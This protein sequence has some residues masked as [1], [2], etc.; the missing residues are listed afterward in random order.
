[1]LKLT[2]SK[3]KI[4]YISR[5]VDDPE[6]R[7]PDIAL[8]GKILKWKPEVELEKG[9]KKTIDYFKDSIDQIK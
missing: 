5:P 2:N 6:K 4:K 3:S 7:K 1:M 9:L 8:A